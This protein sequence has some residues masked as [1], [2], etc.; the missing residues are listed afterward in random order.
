MSIAPLDFAANNC[1]PHTNTTIGE[2][3]RRSKRKLSL[4]CKNLT[5]GARSFR[6]GGEAFRINLEKA[7][8]KSS[9]GDFDCCI[10]LDHFVLD[11]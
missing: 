8:F 9:R 7:L 10:A 2:L 4:S 11:I 6:V 3:F 5:C 1:F